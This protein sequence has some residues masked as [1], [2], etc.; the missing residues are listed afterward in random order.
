MSS[1]FVHLLTLA[2]PTRADH[3]RP[4]FLEPSCPPDEGIQEAH[5]HLSPVLVQVPPPP[6]SHGRFP[7]SGVT[8]SLG[9]LPLQSLYPIWLVTR[10]SFL[11]PKIQ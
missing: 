6:Q 3:P 1:L 10:T 5:Q 2:E 9:M 8:L 11:E 4:S 7:S